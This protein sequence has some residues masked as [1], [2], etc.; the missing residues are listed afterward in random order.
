[1]TATAVAA[2][3]GF[4]A[5]DRHPVGVLLVE[6]RPDRFPLLTILEKRAIPAPGSTGPGKIGAGRPGVA[7]E[8]DQ[9]RDLGGHPPRVCR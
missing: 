2:A 9:L 3:T 8:I 7:E 6:Q 4:A 1:M 5:A